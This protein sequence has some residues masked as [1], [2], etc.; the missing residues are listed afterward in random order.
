MRARTAGV[1][2]IGMDADFCEHT[3]KNL[4]D[5]A[6]SQDAATKRYVDQRISALAQALGVTV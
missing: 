2:S 5:P 4:A 1:L 6:D 3:L